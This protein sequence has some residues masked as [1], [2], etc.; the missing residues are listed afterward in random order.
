MTL[1]RGY[2]N[3]ISSHPKIMFSQV[4][5]DCFV[6]CLHEG[7]FNMG[8]VIISR[9]YSPSKN[10]GLY[11]WK[12]ITDGVTFHENQSETSIFTKYYGN[13]ASP[14]TVY[15]GYRYEIIDGTF[16]VSDSPNTNIIEPGYYT[17]TSNNVT[18]LPFERAKYWTMTRDSS[19][20][21]YTDG[22]VYSNVTY[23]QPQQPKYT[24]Y[25]SYSG[26]YDINNTFVSFVVSNNQSEYDNPTDEFR[27]Q[28]VL[29]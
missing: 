22:Y 7:K 18:D 4:T 9:K 11:C 28:S 12:K 21:M 17:I 19:T 27:Y 26:Y 1:V 14:V 8:N 2:I 15:Y 6:F 20:T 5:L 16:R 13:S 25:L 3:Y 29:R 24:A 10:E 23:P